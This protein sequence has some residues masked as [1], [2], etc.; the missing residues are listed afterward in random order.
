MLF[1][2]IGFLRENPESRDIYSGPLLRE[3]QRMFVGDHFD[4]V[5]RAEMLGTWSMTWVTPDGQ[6]FI[7]RRDKI[8]GR[9]QY[10]HHN[11]YDND[12]HDNHNDNHNDNHHHND[13]DND[14]HDNYYHNN[15][16]NT[17]K[18]THNNKNGKLIKAIIEIG[19][20][21]V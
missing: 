9:V 1:R 6:Q 5:W 3:S 4:P 16:Y 13:Y 17:L 12:D 11:D 7:C 20:A 10:H 14:D 19:R 15:N 21:H 8:S 2:S 18:K